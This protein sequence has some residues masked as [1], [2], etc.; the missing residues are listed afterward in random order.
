LLGLGSTSPAQLIVANIKIIRKTKPMVYRE[1]PKLVLSILLD[2][3]YKNVAF[4]SV[5]I[6]DPYIKGS[7]RMD[8]SVKKLKTLMEKFLLCAKFNVGIIT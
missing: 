1:K 6:K 5:T 7:D 8:V 2:V 3:F 4:I